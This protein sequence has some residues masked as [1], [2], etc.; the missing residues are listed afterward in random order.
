MATV[1]SQIPQNPDTVALEATTG[2]DIVDQYQLSFAT[3]VDT[4]LP[5]GTYTG[6]VLVSVI[7]TPFT[8]H[9]L[10]DI[11][12]MQEMT[13]YVCDYSTED[14]TK[15]LIDTRDGKSYWVAKLKDGNCWMVQNLALDLSTDKALTPED[16]DVSADW[17]PTSSTNGFILTEESIS[18]SIVTQYSWN[19]GKLILATPS[20]MV[21]CNNYGE[22]DANSATTGENLSEVCQNSGIVD[23]SDVN[24][25]DT[26]HAQPGSYNGKELELVS[27][28]E[29]SRQYDAHYLIGNY[30]QYSTATAGDEQMKSS[31]CAKGWKLP[32]ADSRTTNGVFR[33]VAIEDSYYNLTLSYGYPQAS[34][35]E[36]D[37]IKN[38]YTKALQNA[39]TYPFYFIEGGYIG[40]HL[41]YVR[42][43][44]QL[45]ALWSNKRFGSTSHAAASRIYRDEISPSYS[46]GRFIGNNVRCLAR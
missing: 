30:Y 19:L 12:Y 25:Q 18:A 5:A 20:A 22:N 46:N 10:S 36:I 34:E 8:V 6:K 45:G 16:S 15:Q 23:V 44:G 28:N 37:S 43:V 35:Y 31:I 13:P 41:G 7:A 9:S 1:F 21:L 4:S 32:S 33:P 26:F 2:G 39:Y 27:V 14:E 29:G 3:K 38:T 11:T 24:W 42:Y 17:T 40:T